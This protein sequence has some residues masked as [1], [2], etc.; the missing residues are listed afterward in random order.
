[1]NTLKTLRNQLSDDP[2]LLSQMDVD[3][4]LV[5]QRITSAYRG[6]INGWFEETDKYTVVDK[7]RGWLGSLDILTKLNPEFKMLV[8]VRDLSQIY[9]SIENRHQKTALIDF[10]DDMANL[11]AYER[12]EKLFSNNGVVGRPLRL[13]GQ[14][15]DVSIET[16]K[17][18]FY[19]IFE[20]LMQNP[21][22]VMNEV[23]DWLGLNKFEINKENLQVK[24]HES[25]SY[26]R[27]KY[28]HKTYNSINPPTPH[29]L[30]DRIKNDI[31]N[32]F[33]WFYKL[34]YPGVINS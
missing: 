25:D 13:I 27:F 3:F 29:Q 14:L 8:C 10:P 22:R 18:L 20:D 26:Y 11:T 4:D 1:V 21:I 7:N 30:P 23:Y 28:P 34:F 15:Q 17:G 24:P 32:E 19:I 16:Q 31:I 12:A 9:A 6:Y 2:F 33:S 5:Y